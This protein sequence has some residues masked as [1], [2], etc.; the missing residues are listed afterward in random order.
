VEWLNSIGIRAT[1]FWIPKPHG[2]LGD[3]NAAWMAAIREAREQGHDFQLHGLTH[4]CLEF[5]VP[6]ADTRFSP[7][8]AKLFNDYWRNHAKWNAEHSVANLRSKLEEAVSIYKRA[9]GEKPLVFRAPC[10]GI[11]PTAY[12]ALYQVGI[13]YSSSRS[14]NPIATAYTII[15][16]PLLRRWVPIFPC[17]PFV[18]PP[19]VIEIPTMEDLAIH[20]V[21]SRDYDDRLELYKSE[22]DNYLKSGAKNAGIGIFASHYHSMM[23]TWNQTRLLYEEI[24]EWLAKQGVTEWITF[25]EAIIQLEEMKNT[26]ERR[27]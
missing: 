18:E 10:F 24:I 12:E 1:F 26:F 27:V 23:K 20:G 25:R 6:Q 21:S 19:G 8:I 2:R 4:H 11:G 14:V 17:H 13:Y 7:N 22:L 15:R 16:D 5:G 3:R 9:F